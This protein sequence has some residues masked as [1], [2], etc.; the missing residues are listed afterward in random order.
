MPVASQAKQSSSLFS[1][2]LGSLISIE[3]SDPGGPEAAAEREAELV[4]R[5][6]ASVAS[7]RVDDV[8]SDS[9]FL[10]GRSLPRM[11]RAL[12]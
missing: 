12:R 8:F 2:A 4:R 7:C 11:L 9:K 6:S 10:V 1:R 5:A 3:G